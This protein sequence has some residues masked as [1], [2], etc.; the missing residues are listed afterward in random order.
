LIY[1]KAILCFNIHSF[2]EK[3]GK[4]K[5]MAKKFGGPLGIE[6]QIFEQNFR[7]HNLNFEGDKIN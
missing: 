1:K 5:K 3:K 7:A 2:K 6:P 4:E